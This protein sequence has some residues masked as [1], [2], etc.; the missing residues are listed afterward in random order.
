MKIESACYGIVNR[1]ISVGVEVNFIVE[2]LSGLD[3]IASG[4]D[5]SAGSEGMGAAL[6]ERLADCGPCNRNGSQLGFT[7][8]SKARQPVSP[9]FVHMCGDG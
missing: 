3:M 5:G 7:S 2:D 1:L 9:C 6:P 4:S 8:E